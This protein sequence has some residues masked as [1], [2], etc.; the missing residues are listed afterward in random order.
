MCTTL[1]T[2]QIISRKNVT[3]H[4][5]VKR[6]G[7]GRKGLLGYLTECV[8]MPGLVSRAEKDTVEPEG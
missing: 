3:Y 5:G 8:S 7:G 2:H 4:V 1:G 6:R